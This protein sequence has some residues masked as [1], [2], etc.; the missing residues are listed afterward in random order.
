MQTGKEKQ[1]QGL[2]DDVREVIH[3]SDDDS[4][5]CLNHVIVNDLYY[6]YDGK[7]YKC[8]GL[9]VKRRKTQN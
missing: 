4:D 3:I 1:P 2:D 7:H 9:A 6:I 8:H 5:T